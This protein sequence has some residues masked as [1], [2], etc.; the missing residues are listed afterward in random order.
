M[1]CNGTCRDSLMYY[2]FF[3]YIEFQIEADHE[4]GSHT[5]HGKS[6]K[7]D[8]DKNDVTFVVTPSKHRQL[9]PADHEPVVSS[10]SFSGLQSFKVSSPRNTAL[11]SLQ[12]DG[13][14]N[15]GDGA[16]R[17]SIL[18]MNKRQGSVRG[19]MSTQQFGDD[20]EP[21]SDSRT[22]ESAGQSLKRSTISQQMKRGDLDDDESIVNPPRGIF[23]HNPDYKSDS[24]INGPSSEGSTK[25]RVLLTK[26]GREQRNQL[27]SDSNADSAGGG[28]RPSFSRLQRS[29]GV[30][31]S[32]RKRRLSTVIANTAEKQK[33]I[34][35]QGTEISVNK[36]V[37]SPLSDTS[38]PRQ[39]EVRGTPKP[40]VY[41]T[42]GKSS[43][44]ECIAL[45]VE[46]LKE[47][48]GLPPSQQFFQIELNPHAVL[49]SKLAVSITGQPTAEKLSSRTIPLSGET[50]MYDMR[51]GQ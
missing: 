16:V 51:T 43:S 47:Q 42:A 5:K 50:V 20:V 26:K 2:C 41:S 32:K 35:E 1:K 29:F 31:D 28:G 46:Y 22:R 44:S 39:Q 48:R 30:L 36:N 14:E 6:P 8:L 13:H 37:T 34:V 49:V 17:P 38:S 40:D 18:Y 9:F 4:T 7:V 3:I 25:R 15:S 45:I 12:S 21:E 10:R 19:N 23:G 27:V 33:S 11:S 24:S